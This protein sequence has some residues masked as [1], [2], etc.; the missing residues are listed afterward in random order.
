MYSINCITLS[1]FSIAIMLF[2]LRLQFPFCV[3]DPI[4]QLFFLAYSHCIILGKF[5]LK[6]FLDKAF[7]FFTVLQVT[8]LF[9][10]VTFSQAGKT[11]LY[12]IPSMSRRNLFGRKATIN[13]DPRILV[14]KRWLF[15]CQTH[16]SLFVLGEVLLV[17]CWNSIS[18]LHFWETWHI[19]LLQICPLVI[20]E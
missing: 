8:V 15:L 11:I 7:R 20:S 9:S 14:V 5:M 16:S 17:V 19:C 3:I 6:C 4:G 13:G 18:T 1:T 10:Y 12:L 2:S